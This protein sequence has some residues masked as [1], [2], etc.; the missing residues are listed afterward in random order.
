MSYES[1]NSAEGATL[2]DSFDEITLTGQSASASAKKSRSIPVTTV[3]GKAKLPH[4]P[5]PHILP[6]N[7]PWPRR[8]LLN[9]D[10]SLDTIALD[11]YTELPPHH[12]RYYFLPRPAINQTVAGFRPRHP[13]FWAIR[14]V[15]QR[16]DDKH[17]C[18]YRYDTVWPPNTQPVNL[19][20]W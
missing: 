3:D 12:K 5:Y 13:S 16:G 14:D 4:S 8:N 9:P 15:G 17:S 10:G 18:W 7:I 2:I 19:D 20:G 1:S 6:E 11:W